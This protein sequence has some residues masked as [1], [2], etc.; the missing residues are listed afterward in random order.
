MRLLKYSGFRSKTTQDHNIQEPISLANIAAKGATLVEKDSVSE[1]ETGFQVPQ[2]GALNGY[3]GPSY[4]KS[5][6]EQ[7][8]LCCHKVTSQYF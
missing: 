6:S 8:L 4:C 5:L 2:N 3:Q 7:G 1:L